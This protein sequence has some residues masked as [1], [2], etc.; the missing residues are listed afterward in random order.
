VNSLADF[1]ALSTDKILEEIAKKGTPGF[2]PDIDGKFLTEPVLD[3]YLAGKQA[4]IPLLAGFNR[5]EGA[6]FAT[7]MT[8]DKWK[9]TAEERYLERSAEFLK[10]YPGETDAEAQR[11]AADFGGDS[12]I[13]FGTWKWMEIDRKTGDPD[14]YRYKL[15]LASPPSKFHPG[16]F[17]FH[18]DDIEYIFGTL[19]T[20]PGA[21]W[22]PEDRKLSDEMMDYW[23][24]FARAG[25]PNGPGL[26]N[27]PKYGPGDPVL[28][29]D[30]SITARPDENRARYEFWM[31]GEKK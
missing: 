29:L 21:E 18:S 25:D 2:G 31:E 4:H 23:T 14:I 9:S 7:G 12:F 13:A 17:A 19:D 10:L 8:K 24:N 20:R 6:F 28:H 3:I 22:R 5:D 1:R 16:S 11:S 15:D 26:P 27:W 30:S